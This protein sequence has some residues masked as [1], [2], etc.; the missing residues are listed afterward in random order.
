MQLEWMAEVQLKRLLKHPGDH[1]ER[2]PGDRSHRGPATAPG[3]LAGVLSKAPDN[4]ERP[5][6]PL[7]RT[8]AIR[9]GCEPPLPYLKVRAV[10]AVGK[11]AYTILPL[12]CSSCPLAL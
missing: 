3:D 5:Q 4:T 6:L 8:W 10:P 7:T 11:G 1:A 2:A 9:E 12:S